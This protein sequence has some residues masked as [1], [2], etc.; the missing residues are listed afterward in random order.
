MCVRRCVS[1]GGRDADGKHSAADQHLD[2][3][4]EWRCGNET[5]KEAIWKKP[6]IDIYN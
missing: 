1:A 2:V 5:K 3:E 4:K 6:D